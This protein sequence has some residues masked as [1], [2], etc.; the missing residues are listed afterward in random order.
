MCGI[1]GIYHRD[2]RHVDRALLDRATN[3][4]AHR[5]PDDRAE[6][7]EG[8]VGFGHRRLSII[9]LSPSGRQ[10]MSSDD[11]TLVLTYNGE[12]YNFQELRQELE[13]RGV[14]FRSRT[15]SE[16]V[17]RSYECW[18][19]EC[20][21]R[22]NGMFAM[23]IW[24]G[25]QQ[26][27]L[28]AR[29][30]YGIKPLYYHY[31]GTRLMFASEIKAILTDPDISVRVD[32]D[33]LDQ[34]FT[35]QN[36]LTNRTLFDGV[37]VL[38][39]GTLM[40]ASATQVPTVH[41]YWDLALDPD[42][43]VTRGEAVEEL[44]RL[45]VQAVRRQVVSD[46][47]VGSYLSGGI[48]SGSITAVARESLGRLATFTC[49]FDLSSASGLEMACDERANAEAFANL[50]KTEHYEVVLHAGDMEQVMPTLVHHL[51]DLRV[52]QCYPNFYVARLASRFVTVV[53]SGTGGDEL[54]GGYPWRYRLGKTPAAFAEQCYEFWQRLVP[55][56]RKPE[57]FQPHVAKAVAPDGARRAFNR[58]LERAGE[59]PSTP[60]AQVN[61]CLY[62][63]FKTFL[64]GLLMVED[65]VSMAHGLESR[66]PFLDNDLVDFARRLPAEWKVREFKDPP[67][68]DENQPERFRADS[69]R[70][71][72]KVILREA[73]NGLIP[74]AVRNR[75]KQGFSG[76][77]AS[78]FRG[79]SIDY[80][81]NILSASDARINDYLRP[82]FVAGVLREHSAGARNHR[83]LI[84]SLLSFELWL[85]TFMA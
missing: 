7:I 27:L 32:A 59:S 60:A 34:Y 33:A 65:R 45:F 9:D 85:D 2:G 44:R 46:V 77:D 81:T 36:C 6:F 62:F 76:P 68:L 84:W 4:L 75:P 38:E 73:V 40:T 42:R 50:L 72:G 8:P 47:P 78:W 80:V 28:L 79:E 83:L 17:L 51:E 26:R 58:I 67:P 82:Q 24:D 25:R 56:E 41:R 48:D 37:H 39:P 74:S 16:V 35:F 15:D 13:R 64:H 12:V 54:M 53:L 22:L 31:N 63:E 61:A 43:S 14:V 20:L 29:D 18:G 1:V 21:S 11:G 5:G 70:D 30:R 49:G 19:L 71:D 10:P 23:A 52:G 69:R 66:V 55:D 57:L 3:A